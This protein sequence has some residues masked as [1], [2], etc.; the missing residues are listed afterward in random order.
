M[1]T[2]T[3]LYLLV[4]VAYYTMMTEDELLISDAVAVASINGISMFK[5]S[6]GAAFF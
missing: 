4:N 3:T 6:R 1:V 5:M 2:V